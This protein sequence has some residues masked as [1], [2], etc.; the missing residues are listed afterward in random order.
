MPSHKCALAVIAS[1]LAA[2]QP[3]QPTD[4]SDGSSQ[5]SFYVNGSS[6]NGICGGSGVHAHGAGVDGT[7][8][9]NTALVFLTPIP[10]NLTTRGTINAA[11][12]NWNDRLEEA[13]GFNVPTLAYSADGGISV[14][15]PANLSSDGEF[16]G[17]APDGSGQVAKVVLYRLGDGSA[18]VSHQR[19]SL[20]QALTH[21]IAHVL[22]LNQQHGGPAARSSPLTSSGCTSY[23]PP[24]SGYGNLTANVCYHEVET[25]IRARSGTS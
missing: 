16:C 8:N 1:T 22:G 5:P 9:Q 3:A 18:C 14:E 19:G 23:I 10:D 20:V 13:K 21:E 17:G 24:G 11:I 15:F 25:I 7:C 6:N 4:S 2:C 12:G